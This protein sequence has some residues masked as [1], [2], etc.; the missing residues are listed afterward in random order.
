[1]PPLLGADARS[2]Q[3]LSFWV[4]AAAGVFLRGTACPWAGS[5][6]DAAGWRVREALPEAASAQAHIVTTTDIT[7]IAITGDATMPTST[8]CRAPREQ[9]RR[10]KPLPAIA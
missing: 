9:I 4:G 7:A 10:D 2:I 3:A 8:V 6:R 1:M 5:E